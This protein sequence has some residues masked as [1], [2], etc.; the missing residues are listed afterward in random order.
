M[1]PRWP[2]HAWLLKETTRSNK[3]RDEAPSFV[4]N[5]LGCDLY[6]H[7]KT[8]YAVCGRELKYVFAIVRSG[9]SYAESL[10]RKH[11]RQFKLG[12]LADYCIAYN[13]LHS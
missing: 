4:G 7:G 6:K 1:K 5:V 12:E 9:F 11:R 10:H 13:N 8:Y 3:F 2:Q